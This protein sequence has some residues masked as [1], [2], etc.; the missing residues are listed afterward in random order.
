MK[1]K[2]I[3]NSYEYNNKERLIVLF[4]AFIFSIIIIVSYI[5][6]NIKT[7]HYNKIYDKRYVDSKTNLEIKP[8]VVFPLIFLIVE[9][10]NVEEKFQVAVLD[11]VTTKW[12]DVNKIDYDTMIIGRT[13]KLFY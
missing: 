11:G 4:I 2:L 8:I 3:E 9:K 12:I 10:E 5:L 7:D 1:P 13:Y 6:F